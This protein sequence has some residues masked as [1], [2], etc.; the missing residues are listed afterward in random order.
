MI[1]NYLNDYHRKN[2]IAV[3]EYL[4]SQKSLTP[5]EMERQTAIIQTS[6]I[7]LKNVASISCIIKA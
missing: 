3:Q 1:G 2:Q 5:E 4:A 7:M 6:V